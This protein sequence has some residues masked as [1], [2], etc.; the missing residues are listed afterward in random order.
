[1]TFLHVLELAL[2]RVAKDAELLV[3]VVEESDDDDSTAG[4]TTG[5]DEDEEEE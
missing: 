2:Y 1:M 3:D 4:A 5:D